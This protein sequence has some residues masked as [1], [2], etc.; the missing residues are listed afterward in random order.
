[1]RIF[2]KALFAGAV[3][4]IFAGLA[5]AEGYGF[6]VFQ[7]FVSPTGAIVRGSGVKVVTHQSTGRYLVQFAR[8]V[9]MNA[10]IY[11]ATPYSAHGGQASMTVV[12]GQPDALQ[13]FTFSRIGVPTN[14]YF[15]LVV[16]CV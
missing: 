14:L 13:V 7:A 6:A 16:S 8:Q 5:S 3:C 9:N 15:N 11:T 1:M 4:A 10:C 2:K 12:P